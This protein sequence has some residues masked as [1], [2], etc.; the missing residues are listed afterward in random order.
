MKVL[1]KVEEHY[2]LGVDDISDI[3]SLG[4]DKDHKDRIIRFLEDKEASHYDYGKDGQDVMFYVLDQEHSIKLN[5]AAHS[6]KQSSM[7]YVY[8]FLSDM[9]D[10]NKRMKLRPA[11]S[12]RWRKQKK[13]RSAK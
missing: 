11:S 7:K 5:P 9:L 8:Y 10:P 1:Y 6:S 12:F 13:R 3:E 4:I 2:L